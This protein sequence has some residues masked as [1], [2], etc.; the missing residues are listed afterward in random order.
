MKEIT[1]LMAHFFWGNACVAK[2]GKGVSK[3]DGIVVHVMAWLVPMLSL[4]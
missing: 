2:K 4:A 1:F 3:M